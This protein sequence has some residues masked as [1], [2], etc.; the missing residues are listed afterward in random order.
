MTVGGLPQTT[1]IASHDL[2]MMLETCQRVIL[3]SRGKIAA[4]GDAETAL[5]DKALLEAN[6]RER[7]C[8]LQGW[9]KN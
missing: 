5:L 9:H 3:L 6:R 7:R 2:E 8:G 4:D 1:R